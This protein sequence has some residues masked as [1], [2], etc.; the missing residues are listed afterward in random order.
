MLS[1]AALK[2]VQVQTFSNFSNVLHDILRYNGAFIFV[3]MKPP[4]F[5][6]QGRSSGERSLVHTLLCRIPVLRSL[7]CRRVTSPSWWQCSFISSDKS[8]NTPAS[9]IWDP[10]SHR[11][12]YP[13]ISNNG[14]FEAIPPYYLSTIF[15]WGPMCRN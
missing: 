5:S 6:F 3:I 12:A 4:F 15:P 2:N 1:C 14:D 13:D 9:R 7:R 10:P 8:R 11:V